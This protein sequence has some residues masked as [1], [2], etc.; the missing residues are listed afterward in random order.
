MNSQQGT[1]ETLLKPA[2]FSTSDNCR[3]LFFFPELINMSSNNTTQVNRDWPGFKFSIRS[4]WR[5]GWEESKIPRR[6]LHLPGEVEFEILPHTHAWRLIA[7][8]A[9][10]TPGRYINVV[11]ATCVGGAEGERQP[12]SRKLS[13]TSVTRVVS[14]ALK[15]PLQCEGDTS[16]GSLLNMWRRIDFSALIRG[17][18]CITGRTM[19]KKSIWRPRG[20]LPK[21]ENPWVWQLAGMAQCRSNAGSPGKSKCYINLRFNVLLVSITGNSAHLQGQT[22]KCN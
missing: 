10:R 11:W 6:W 20:R 9:S 13:V 21:R 17:H 7:G 3:W 4:D 14:L 16:E 15:T 18:S 2:R 22:E 1:G 12:R 8:C 19:Y 5:R